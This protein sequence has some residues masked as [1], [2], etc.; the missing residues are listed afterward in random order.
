[1]RE[2]PA[3][4]IADALLNQRVMAGVGNVYKSEVLFACGVNPFTPVAALTDEQ[5]DV[6]DRRPRA[7]SWSPTSAPASRR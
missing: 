5:L 4:E 7:T 2:R 3:Q 6:P 1:M